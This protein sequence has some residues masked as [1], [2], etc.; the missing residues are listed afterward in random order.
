MSGSECKKRGG[1]ETMKD[2]SHS[3]LHPPTLAATLA[4]DSHVHKHEYDKT[5]NKQ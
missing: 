4:D 5:P 2:V 3:I 1:K